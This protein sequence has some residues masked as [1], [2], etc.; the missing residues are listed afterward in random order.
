MSSGNRYVATRRENVA[1]GFARKRK[2]LGLEHEGHQKK[3]LII[4]PFNQALAHHFMPSLIRRMR[5]KT[6]LTAAS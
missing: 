6:N 3:N 2:G 1:T 4:P 5:P